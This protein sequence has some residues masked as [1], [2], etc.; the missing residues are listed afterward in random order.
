MIFYQTLDEYNPDACRKGLVNPFVCVER[1]YTMSDMTFEDAL[2]EVKNG[3][4]EGHWMWW[5]FPQMK[6]LGKSERSFF[7]GLSGQMEANAYINNPILGPRLI[8]ITQAVLDNEKTPYEI[9][10]QDLVKFRACMILFVSSCDLPIFR[11]ACEK[12]NWI[13]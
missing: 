5:T 13:I 9:F 6:G 1:F 12:Y 8:E 10:G 11:Q 3:K 7:Y 2:K 4:K